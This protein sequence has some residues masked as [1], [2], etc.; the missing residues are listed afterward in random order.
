M[1]DLSE[2]NQKCILYQDALLSVFSFTSQ[3]SSHVT[4][5]VPVGFAIATEVILV[6]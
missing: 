3:K 1:T 4:V 5:N 2:K 6:C